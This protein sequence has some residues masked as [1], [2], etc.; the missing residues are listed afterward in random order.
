[1]KLTMRF[2]LAIVLCAFA[3]QTTTEVRSDVRHGPPYMGHSLAKGAKYTLT[4]F[5]T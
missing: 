2:L 4:T 5:R 3:F 1:M